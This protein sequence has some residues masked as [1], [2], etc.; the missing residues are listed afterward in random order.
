MNGQSV[1]TRGITVRSLF[2]ALVNVCTVPH[3]VQVQSYPSDVQCRDTKS[4]CGRH[5]LQTWWASNMIIVSSLSR[6]L[7]LDTEQ[8]HNSCRDT[9]HYW[10]VLFCNRETHVK[11][12]M[13]A[14][15]RC[16]QYAVER[17][18]SHRSTKISEVTTELQYRVRQLNGDNFDFEWLS[19]NWIFVAE[20]L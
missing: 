19:Q 4:F 14:I 1:T 9:V 10:S 13:T 8:L 2:S 16:W 3:Y 12:R 15:S 6:K 17:R 11:F 7:L 5:R 20:I 18:K